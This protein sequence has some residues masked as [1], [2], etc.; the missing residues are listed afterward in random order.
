VYGCVY[1]CVYVCMCVYVCVC[2]L[3]LKEKNKHVTNKTK[4][5]RTMLM[6]KENQSII[7]SGESGAGKTEAAKKIM[8]YIA[9]VTG[10]E[11]GNEL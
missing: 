8:Y 9:E 3:C 7:I 2:V 10:G 5:N 4:Q 11:K 1:G 6:E